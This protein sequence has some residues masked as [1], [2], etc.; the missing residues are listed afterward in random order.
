MRNSHL[1]WEPQ[2]ITLSADTAT[3]VAPTDGQRHSARI[4]VPE[5]S[6]IRVAPTQVL[7][8]VDATSVSATVT[9]DFT[10]PSQNAIW[11]RSVGEDS[12]LDVILFKY[13]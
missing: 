8:G 12:Y 6:D 1:I 10:L 4:F 2:R 5:G 11:A 9:S 13:A 7:V 3:E